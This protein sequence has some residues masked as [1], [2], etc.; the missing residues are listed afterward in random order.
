MRAWNCLVQGSV[1]ACLAF[2]LGVSAFAYNPISTYHYLADPGA[3]ADD[4]YF[5]II[6]DSDD[7]APHNAEGYN[8][9]ALYGFRSRDMQNWT[10]LG[11]IFEA[12]REMNSVNDIWASGIAV[13]D[14]KFYIVFPDGGGGGIGYIK[15][16]ALEGPWTNAVN[17]KDKLVAGWGNGLID[18]DG[19]S[20]CFDP[21]VFIDDDGTSYVTWGGG[22]STSRPNTDNFDVVKLNSAKNGIDGKAQHVKVNNLPT[23]KML[24]ASFIHKHEGKYYF[25]YST[26]WQQGAPTIDYG[27]SDNPMGPYTWKGTILEDP[28]IGGKSIN[29]NNNH[30]GIAEFKGHSYAV[31]HDRRIAKGHDGLEKIPANDGVPAPNEGYHRS[32]SI[33]EMFYNADGTIKS[34][35]FT[36]EGPEQIEN[37]NPYEAYPALTSSK[38]RGV[39]SHTDW[40]K[41]QPVTHVL[42]PQASTES[43]IRVSGVD[44]GGGATG[45]RVAAASTADGNKIEIRTGSPTGTLAGTCDI[46]QTSGIK[47]YEDTECEVSGLTGTV[48]QLF[49]V[50]KVVKDGSLALIE[51]EFS[52]SGPSGAKITQVPY[53][54]V[55]TK[56]PAKIEAEH[57]DLGGSRK[58]Y[59]DD[60]SDNQGDAE[61][62][63]TEGVDIVLGGSGKAVGYTNAGEWLEYTVDVPAD[64]EYA[65]KAN[66]ASGS[67]TSGFI[68]QLDAKTLLGDTVKVPQTGEDWNTYEVIDAGKAK[69]TA[70][71]HEIRLLITGSFVNIDWFS[72]G[73]VKLDEAGTT[74][75]P[76]VTLNYGE[77]NEQAYRVFSVNGKFVG[78]VELSGKTAARALS[79]AGFD[80]GIYMLRSVNGNKKFMATVAK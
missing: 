9:K 21:S 47:S 50:F 24:E 76:A 64:G 79:E 65:I 58:G 18:C 10:D 19:V 57:F 53:D 32:V 49:L 77:N 39:R 22:E 34:V 70:G 33:D 29:G 54:S 5:Y 11:I 80:K 71:T 28:N 52:G 72:L 61:F 8:I 7:P 66:V 25:S 44:F 15:A 14:G 17:G 67:E 74:I 38:Q 48:E 35:K 78:S 60:D 1:G 45:F 68:L 69:L 30:H 2:G 6:T 46:K 75:T 41:G 55:A 40:T 16:D 26:G 63:M 23:R 13:Y 31:Y 73:D 4:E 43:W 51:W 59:S 3:A 12:K 20:W 42:T 27:M 62:R 37:F 56:L 36:N